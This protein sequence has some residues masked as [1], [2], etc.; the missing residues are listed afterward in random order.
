MSEEKTGN[1]KSSWLAWA[2]VLPQVLLGFLNWHA[3]V[4]VRGDMSPIQLSRAHAIGL[5]EVV[6]L[7]SGCLAWM[8][9]TIRRKP[10]GVALALATVAVHTGYLWLF[11]QSLDR[12]L[13]TTVSLWMM[14]QTE[15]V[16]YQFSL[17]MPVIFLMLVRLARIRLGLSTPVDVGLSLAA[18]VVI[19]A[20]AFIFGSL[21][22]RLDRLMW[23]HENLQYLLIAALVAATAF[24]LVAF[25]R[26]LGRLHDWIGKKPW[27]EWAIPLAAGAVGPLAG[28]AL[29]ASIPFPYDFQSP[30]VYGMAL[31]NAA[32][33]LIPFQP[34]NRWA[35]PGWLA[36]VVFYPFTLYFFLVFL[37]FLP[38]SLLA[39]IAAGSG[40]LILAP[41]FLFVVHTRRLWEQSHLLATLHG[42]SRVIMVFAASILLLPA[43]FLSRNIA[44]RSALNRALDTVFS[45]DFAATRVDVSAASLRR[46]LDRMDDMKHGLY[47]PYLSDIY[48]SMVFRGMVLPDEKADLI[49]KSLLGETRQENSRLGFWG[50][51][52]FGGRSRTGR[53]VRGAGVTRQVVLASH[54]ETRVETNGMA[55]T[56]IRFVLENRGGAN[57]EYSE[58]MT[59]PEGVL[60]SGFWLDV[61]G[62]NKPAQLRERKAATWVYEMIRD[63]TRRDPG[64]VVYEDDQHLRLRVF[65]FAA[66]EKRRCGLKF[67]FPVTLHPSIRFAE[68]T[69]ALTDYSNTSQSAS[70]T[71]ADGL[72]ALAIPNAVITNLPTFRREVVVH[73][74][75][76]RSVCAATNQAAVITRARAAIAALPPAITRICL[77]WANYEQEDT[78]GTDMS[79]EE[80][81]RAL[82]RIPALPHRGGFCPERVIARILLAE[83]NAPRSPQPAGFAPLFV[84]VP[85]PGSTPVQTGSLVPFVRLVPDLPA[86]AVFDTNGFMRIAFQTG[87]RTPF[88]ASDCIPSNSVALRNG[89]KTSLIAAHQDALVFASAASSSDWQVWNPSSAQFEPLPAPLRCTDPAYLAGL[90]L[91]AHHRALS[92]APGKLDAALPG[93][94]RDSRAAGLLIPEAAFIVLETQ[95]Q[96][97]ML[98]RKERQSLGANHALEFDEAKEA[99][100]EKAPTPPM[101][102]L[103]IPAFWLLGRLKARKAG[104]DSGKQQVL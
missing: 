9:Q 54:E 4:L 36:R 102:W 51:D 8:V 94:V 12:L 47:L 98:A 6:L 84:V 15:L 79:R 25:L 77:T 18:L 21:L 101:V 83:Y 7:A 89:D 85:A 31:L 19:P 95:S 10:I 78:P 32:S 66:G 93:L 28:L 103:I 35:Y 72:T 61:N 70:A 49:R 75:L 100:T 68:T 57:G 24:I 3:W 33:L 46:A 22:V 43:L 96:E 73:L 50:R 91:W 97:V 65:P 59:V 104:N 82:D 27:S 55:E 5:F 29:N 88:L 53:R 17:I 14:P 16:F 34:G 38:L 45:P 63:M 13:P 48:D 74:I 20:G 87:A 76:D 80:A 62:T 81:V 1:M 60:V 52:V 90:S 30:A 64:L 71:L 41:L 67:R 86:Y 58:R 92:W 40:F 39:M 44:D 11:L 23:R 37:P 2:W 56:E 42:P 69:V 26:V 99:K